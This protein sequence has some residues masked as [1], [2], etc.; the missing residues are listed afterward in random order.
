VLAFAFKHADHRFYE[1][2]ALN[3]GFGNPSS[4]IDNPLPSFFK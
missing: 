3:A 4:E 2:D 1:G